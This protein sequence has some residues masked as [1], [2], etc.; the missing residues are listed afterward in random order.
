MKERKY[1]FDLAV[2]GAGT[3]GA[4]AA[5]AAADSGLK[6]ILIDQMGTA[7]GSAS[8][9]L[10]TPMMM[11][12]IKNNPMC[13]YISDEINR[14]M[15]ELGA[16]VGKG[17]NW[18]DPMI[19]SIV[20]EDML[21]KRG[22]KVLFHTTVVGAKR[23]GRKICAVETFSKSGKSEI[24]ADYF[25]DATGDADVCELLNLPILH[26]NEEDGKNQPVSLR[27]ILGG[28]DIDAF[29]AF[30]RTHADPDAEIP[31]RPENYDAAVTL[32]MNRIFPLRGVFFEAIDKGDLLK[33][34][35]TYWQVF[36]IP[37]RTDALA[38]NCPEFFDLHDADD[39]ENLTY[40]Q[41]Q[42]KQAIMRQ[43]LFYKKYFKGFD[44]A[45]IAQIASLVG[46]RESRRAVTDYVITKEDCHFH[47][48]FEDAVCIS[49]YP[50]DIHGRKLNTYAFEAKRDPE[51]PYYEIPLRS[52]IVRDMDNLLV[53]GRN[54]G[55][56]FVA[57]SSVRVMPT[58][59]AIGEA[60]GIAVSIAKKKALST[61]HEVD[62]RE[63][64][65]EMLNRGAIFE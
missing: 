64:K 19:L 45:Y 40:V 16:A 17:D 10:V 2:L 65:A 15:V 60:A 49:N 54:I 33:E 27:Y 52:L 9:S 50:V 44:H 59:R 47:R 37:G 24:Y 18:F 4:V 20:L 43:L 35:A 61:L 28:V 8:L 22:V 12:Y 53:A 55:S 7:G 14:K 51:K 30:I 29:W 62:G 31:P 57:Q 34:D 6:V 21:M 5:I 36:T 13:S 1:N 39:A 42:G 25:I 63:V 41:L 38:F 3:A 26:G 11:L 32:D 56:E 58:C 23:D 48:K 46:I